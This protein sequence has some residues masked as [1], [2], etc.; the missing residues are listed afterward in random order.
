MQLKEETKRNIERV[1]GLPFH[2]IECLTLEEEIAHVEK[3]TGARVKFPTTAT[4]LAM[5]GEPLLT[6]GRYRTMEEVDA[7][8]DKMFPVRSCWWKFKAKLKGRKKCR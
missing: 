1:V 4:P 6:I 3:R 7:Y 2:Q 8:F 5:T